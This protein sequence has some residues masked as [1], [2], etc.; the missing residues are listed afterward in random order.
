VAQLQDGIQAT[1]P[2]RIQS[3]K[4]IPLHRLKRSLLEVR[5]TD[6]TGVLCLKWFHCPKGMEKRFLP[7]IQIV[8]SGK[9]KYYQGKPEIVHP[10]ITWGVSSAEVSSEG[11]L[12]LGRVVPIY[13]EIEGVSSRILRK[14][15]WEAL[16]KFRSS[17]L[18]DLPAYLLKRRNLP[19][20]SQAVRELHFPTE[21]EGLDLTLLSEFNTPSHHRL[22]YGEFFKFEYLILRRRLNLERARAPI[23]NGISPQI[24]PWINFL[25]FQL[26]QGQIR[27]VEEILEDLAQ[28]YPMNRL[29]QGDVGSG[30]TVV[31]LLTAAW[32]LSCGGQVALM[33]PTEILAEQHF[34]TARNLFQ[35][36]L[37]VALLTGKSSSVERGELQS[38]LSAGT[39]LLVIGTHA[40]L[41]DTVSF[42][43]LAY[44]M[45]DEQ[46]RFGVEQRRTLRKKGIQ[47]VSET[48]Q[49]ILPH[50]LILTATPIP[51]TLAL[52]AFG[53]LSVSSITELPPGRSPVRT[54]VIRDKG[55]RARAY[56]LIRQELDQGRQ[57]YFIY[58]L[59][60]ESEAEGFT[61]LK[62]AVAQSQVLSQEVFPEFSVSLLHGQMKSDEKEEVMNRFKRGE[63]NILVSTTVVEVGVDVPNATVMTIEHAERFGLSQLHQLRGRVGR[64]KF[65]SHCFLFT[66]TRAEGISANR[67]E[68][69]EETQD[70][71]KIAEADLEIRGPGEFL[72]IKQAGGL[73]FKL[74]NLV[75][76]RQWLLTARD[77]AME[78]MSQDPD[79]KNP[80][81]ASL[82]Q[83]YE[84]EG[85]VQFN[86]LNTS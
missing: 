83:Y 81:H 43:R 24:F 74:A 59:V 40:L 7:N 72:G 5:C 51:R 62:S 29:V 49:V 61:Q 14:V 17:L 57:A 39:A 1:V 20:L 31:A 76:D 32:V 55:Q 84:R 47:K 4:Q 2:V 6:G 63:V 65:Q 30:K 50:S 13:S 12:H 35:G 26:T 45:I 78:V 22:I 56:E 18:E 25:P 10:E 52:T 67:L 28:S 38:R 60:N 8:V 23:L 3:Q 21:V 41:E 82:R 64:G 53:D 85:V 77:D 36:K 48:G 16:E 69:L 58:P 70:G 54:Q 42:E 68:I 73:P 46:H 44:V 11:Q 80:E 79:L 66:Q 75:R 37:E 19:C 33:A 9:V 15:L 71:F 34:K 27:A 86:R